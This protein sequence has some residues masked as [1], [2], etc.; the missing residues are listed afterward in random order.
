MKPARET[1]DRAVYETDYSIPELGAEPGDLIVV[2]PGHPEVPMLV[3]REF[4]RNRLPLILEHLDRLVPV[5][6]EGIEPSSSSDARRWLTSHVAHS[7]GLRLL[8]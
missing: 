4:D 3:V 6:F 7:Q 1:A 8:R 2:E 5:S